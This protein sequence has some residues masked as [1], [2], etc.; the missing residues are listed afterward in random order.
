MLKKVIICELRIKDDSITRNE[1]AFRK[2]I[3]SYY[4]NLFTSEL[5]FSEAAYDTF[6][7]NI[8]IPKLSEDAFM[9]KKLWRVDFRTRSAG[10][11]EAHEKSEL[12]RYHN[13]GELNYFNT[14][15]RWVT[16]RPIKLETDCTA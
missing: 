7:K 1:T 4:R 5:A 15:R 2:E 6:T 11:N 3:G 8:E 13:E 14:E 9:F 16:L 10:F 12:S